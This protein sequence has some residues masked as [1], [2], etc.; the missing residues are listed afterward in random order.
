MNRLDDLKLF[1]RK[2]H[3]LPSYR[4]MLALFKLSSKNAIFKMVRKWIQEG[5][6]KSEDRKLQPTSKFFSLPLLGIVKAGMPVIAE[7]NREYLTLEEYLIENPSTSFLLKVSGDSL[8]Q[9]GIYEGD[10]AI[11][12]KRNQAVNGD[13][14]LAEI[15]HEWTLKIL[16][17]DR[18]KNISYLEPA[19]PKYPL[20]YPKHELKIHGIVK[21][22]VRKYK[23]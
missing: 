23:N 6:I 21:A 7:E 11:I 1:Y 19:N 5:F 2:N 9:K 12:E 14:V 8:I 4:E 16:R 18:H 3:R 15:D 20:L 13:I 10:I 17:K 22:V